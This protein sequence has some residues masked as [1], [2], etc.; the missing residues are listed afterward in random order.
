MKKFFTPSLFSI[1]LILLVGSNVALAQCPTVAAVASKTHTDVTCNGANNGTIT[2]DLGAGNGTPPFNFELYDNNSGSFVTL[3]VTRT[4]SPP[5]KVVFSNVYPGSFQVVVFRAG[6]PSIQIAEGPT[7]T[8]IAEPPALSATAAVTPACTPGTG[9]I[10]LTVTGGTPNVIAPFYHFVWSGPTPIGD[11]QSANNLAAGSY[12]VTV[13]DANSCTFP[14]N[15][16]IVPIFTTSAAGPDQNVCGP[17]ATLAGNTFLAGETGTWTVVSGSGSFTDNHDP[18]TVVSGLALGNNVLRW[19][20]TD[21]GGTCPGNSDDVTITSFDPATVN[22]GVDQIICGGST[23]TLAGA[24]GGSATVGTWSGGGGTFNP[25]ATTLNAIYT[26]SA[27]EGIAGTVTLTLTTD[28][29]VGPCPSVNDQVTI[30]IDQ[31]ASVNAGV[32][33]IICG[34]NTV[35]LAGSIG[36]AA[37]S[38]TWSGGTGTFNPNATTLNAVYTP[39]AAEV[40]A[41]TVTLT[42]TT[43]DPAGPCPAVNDQMII[44]INPA[45]TVTAGPDQIICGGSTVTLA[46]AIGGSATAGTWSGGAGTFNPNATTLNAIYTLTA[47]EIASG[48]VTLTLTTD[49]PPGLCPS[50]NDQMIITVNPPPAVTAGVDQVICAGSTVNLGGGIGGSATG[51]TWSGGSGTFNPNA[52]TLNAVYTPSAAEVTAGTVTLTLTTN[53]PPGPCPSVNDQMTITINPGATVNAGV[54]QISCGGSTVSLAGSIGGSAT[55]GTWSGGSGTFNP[56]ATT[57]NAV[58]TPSAAEVTAGTVTLTLTTNDPAGPCPAVNDQMIVTIN[59]AATVNAGVDQISCAGSTVTLS[60]AIGGS[61]T[62]GTWSGGSGTFNPNTTTLNAVYTPSAAEI[63]AGTVTLTLT[64]DDPAGSCTSV[65]DQMTITINSPAT[66]NAGVDQTICGGTTATLAGAIGGSAI[67]GTWSGGTG[68]FNPNATTLNAVYTPSAAEVTAGTVTLTLTTNDPAGPCPSVND[69][70]IITIDPAAT[71]NAGPDQ[72][73]CVGSTVNLGG[74]IGGSATVGTWSGGTGTFNPNVTTL[75]AIYTPSAAEVTAGT[76]TLTLTTDDPAGPCPSVND[77]MIITINPAATVNAGVDQIIC[78]GSTATLAG[79]IGGSATIGT[80]SGG[81][82]TFNPNAATLNAVYTPS[83]AEVTAGTLTLTLTTDDP[84]GPCP[85]VNDQMIVTINPAAAVNAGP[86]QIICVGSTVTLGGG[87]GGSA[88]VGTWSG[89]SGTFNP[90]VTTLNA[91]YTPSA[92]EV[93]AGTVT[94]TLTTDDPLG[95]CPSVNDNMVITINPVATVN[96]GVDQTICGGSTVTLAGTIGGSATVGTWSG[97]TGTF[98]PNATTLNAV[99]TPSA[100]EVTAGTLTLTLTTDD[101]IGPCPSVNDQMIVTI[102]P[103]AAVTAGPDQVICSVSTVN[104]GGGI[105]GSATVGTWTGGT[106]TFNPDATTLN[107]VYTP[108]AAEVTAGTVTLTLTTDDPPGICPSVNDNM[109]ITINPVAT[110]NAGVDQTVCGGST[111]TLAGTIGGAATSGT[112]TGGSGNFT[113][114]A[115]TLNAVYTPSA[116]EGTAGTVTLTLT[117]NDPAGPCPSVND[118][119]TITI[120]PAATADAGVDQTICSGNTVSLSGSIGGSATTGSWIGGAGIFNPNATTLNTV[121]TPTAAEVAAGTVALTL[122]T[123]DPAGVCPAGSDQVIITIRPIAGNP[124]TSGIDTWLGYVYDDSADPTPL[125]ARI[126]FSNAKYRGFINETDIG[127]MDPLSSYNSATDKFDLNISNNANGFIVHSA[128]LC[129]S[130]NDNFSVRYRMKKTFAQ[131]IYTFTIGSDEGIRFFIDGGA[132]LLPAGAF[133]DQ[134]YT[135]YTTAAQC[136]SAGQHDLVIEYYEHTGSSRLTFDYQVAPAPTVATPVTSCVNSPAPTLTASSADP[137][138]TG[139]NWYKDAALTT[140]LF[141]GPNF[142]PLAADLDMTLV[143]TTSFYATATYACG[144]TIAA[145]VDVNIVSSATITPPTPPEQICQSGGMVDLTTVV[146]A[147]PGGGTFT[148]SGTGVTTSPNFDP[149]LVA[150]TTTITTDYTSGTCTAT[151]NFNID[152]VSVATITVPGSAIAVCQASAPVDMTTLVSATPAG[153]AFTFTG[154]GVTGNTFDPSAQSGAV[155]ITVNY[156][157]GGCTDTKTINFTVSPTAT[158]TITNPTTCPTAGNLL[159]TAFVSA[160]PAGG[161]F[162]F[163]GPG[164]TGNNFDPLTHG[165]SV[166]TINVGYSAG[167]CAAS[168]TMSVTVNGSC[169]GVNCGTFTTSISDTRP[170]CSNQND[171]VININVSGGTPN[172][173]VTLTDGGSFNQALAGPGPTFTFTNLSPADYQYTLQDANGNSCTLPHSLPIQA[174]VLATANQFIDAV[175][176]NQAVGGA[177]VTVNSGGAAPFE[178]SVDGGTSWIVFTSPVT[179]N[180]LMPSASPYSILVRDDATDLCPAQVMVTIHNA[181]ADID[182]PY[183]ITN[184][185]CNNNDGSLQIGTITGGTPP[186]S[187]VMDGVP[188]A[189]LPTNN[190]FTSLTGGAHLF[191]VVDAN[192]CQKDF[193]VIVSFPGLVSFSITGVNPDCTGNGTNGQLTVTI[194]SVGSFQVGVSAD[195]VTPPASFQNVISAGSST[196]TFNGLGQG[197]YYITAKSASAQCPTVTRSTLTAGP[198]AVDFQLTAQDILCSENKGGVTLKGI[199]GSSTVPYNYQILNLGNIVQSGVITSLQAIADVPLTGLDRGDYQIQLTQDQSAATGCAGLITSAFKPFTINGPTGSL[200]TLYVNRTISLPDLATGSMLVGIQ[201]SGLEPYEVRLELTQPFFAQ[202]SYLLD[203]TAAT[204]NP[205]NLK[206]EYNATKLFAGVYKLSLRDAMGCEREYS[207]TIEVNTDVF[208]PNIFTPNNDGINDVFFIRNLPAEAN[209]VI[210]NRWGS[211]VYR[212]SNYANDWTGGNAQDGI[213]YYRLQAGGHTFTGWLEIQR[214]LGQP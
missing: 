169:G 212:S 47:A 50:V 141:N 95:I 94:L 134:L 202:Q 136:I 21:N 138:V 11:Q 107:A 33:Q 41:G 118:Q 13:T 55:T 86:D 53:D 82:G 81:T 22:A 175:C 25:N 29:P 170:S 17:A 177:T 46:G 84:V 112:W 157:A 18:T 114:N 93:T 183:T 191:T 85:S 154:A 78:G 135:T 16:I 70:M 149:T 108:S 196:V 1:F 3:A 36:G 8:N 115:T 58:Y 43:D 165:G 132:N 66:V 207:L 210:T 32:D 176:F 24:I 151:I 69:Q 166:V 100:A 133:T 185:T 189:N 102:N 122:T 62:V 195:P 64:T 12:N 119:V 59:Q 42:L 163:S 110:V 63:T 140:L 144:E 190:T 180:N 77:Q 203:W 96:A 45:A 116:A 205:Q 111:V 35:T 91:V 143:A 14:L 73:I 103:A 148:F 139:F 6:C 161:V 130:Y 39:S 206:V 198:I 30:T 101:P 98:N 56:N 75:N 76:V 150:G 38:G 181:L 54:D 194:T 5:N 147:V 61:A 19:T 106:G 145:K 159:L 213:F 146:S 156:D 40:T 193:P 211:E 4:V 182:A 97:G 162:T 128:N 27:A 113:P 125:P 155:A 120:D 52:T 68:I 123:D 171:G 197:T 164:V 209:I 142:T 137:G 72:I 10:S 99:Y 92:A 88:T 174:T 173:I 152:V 80:W 199:L 9:T 23:V 124:L 104:L 51:G 105:G 129:G 126:N 117:T 20:I 131:G 34:G 37:A 57:L 179:I 31:A 79:A 90:N 48:T 71:V 178:Y 121:Y 167:G 83:A 89:G 2:V 187:Y 87:I 28:D 214:G 44:T 158:L 49:D 7:G 65:N 204:R 74:G 109:V 184:A 188:F 168:G 200:D 172:Y 208:I 26:P 15:N 192:S 153:G 186:Y 60:G 127:A 67:A 201:E 160:V